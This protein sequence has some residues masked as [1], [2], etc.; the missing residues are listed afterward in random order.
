MEPVYVP[1][2][3]MELANDTPDAMTTQIQIEPG[4]P[5]N[6]KWDLLKP[7]IQHLYI[8]EGKKLAEV[9]K[10]L[11]LRYNFIAE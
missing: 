7:V 8:D 1:L 4:T 3:N 2:D 5:F 11:E 10:T 6:K 9:M